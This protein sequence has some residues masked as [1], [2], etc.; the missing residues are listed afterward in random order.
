MCAGRPIHKYMNGQLYKLKELKIYVVMLLRQVKIDCPPFST[1][2][3]QKMKRAAE[4]LGCCNRPYP[5]S[6]PHMEE[7]MCVQ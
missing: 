6:V 7:N 4:C 1:F 2:G 3:T 5:C